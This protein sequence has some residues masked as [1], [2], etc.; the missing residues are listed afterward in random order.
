M[1]A[2]QLVRCSRGHLY[3]T[4]WWHWASLMAVRV[5]PVSWQRC[6]VEDRLRLTRKVDPAT[7]STDA[8]ASA[9]AASGLP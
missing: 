1:E 3:Y 5:G 6:P 7:V 4:T 9:A 8:L 2:R